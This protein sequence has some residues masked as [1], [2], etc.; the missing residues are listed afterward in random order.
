MVTKEESVRV[1]KEFKYWGAR[2]KG[3]KGAFLNL[4][5]LLLGGMT[6]EEIWERAGIED[7]DD[8]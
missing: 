8:V 4:E 2:K 6:R 5:D 1:E 7:G 3:R